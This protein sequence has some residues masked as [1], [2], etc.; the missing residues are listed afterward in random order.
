MTETYGAGVHSG[1]FHGQSRM[2]V[3]FENEVPMFIWCSP[4]YKARHPERASAIVNAVNQPLMTDVIGQMM[5]WLGGVESQWNDS[6][7][8]VLHPA[9]RP[10]KRLIYDTIDYDQLMS[11]NQ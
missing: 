10:V 11:G 7:R 9:Y 6:T 1:F 8:N 4:V 2:M 3:K 5:L